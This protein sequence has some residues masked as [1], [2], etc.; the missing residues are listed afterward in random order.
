M[1]GAWQGLDQES[2]DRNYSDADLV[3]RLRSY[4][5]AQKRYFAV[6]GFTVVL[7]SLADL[8]Q[9]VIVAQGVG[10]LAQN[11]SAALM[12]LV[13][14]A[15]FVAAIG[16]WAANLFRRRATGRAIGDIVRQM[17]ED[18]FK[19]AVSRDMSFY[20]EFSS[21]KIVS[22]ITSDTQDFAQM[23]VLVTD[24]ISQ[25]AVLILLLAILF[26]T[27]WRLTLILCLMIP[28]ILGSALMYRNL[29]R[30]VSR[31]ASRMLA[32]V[33]GNIQESV[34]GIAVAKNFRQEAT[35]YDEFDRVN[36]QSYH[37][38][39][40]RGLIIA[41]VYPTLHVLA[42]LGTAAL[43][44][45]GARSVISG[46]IS[47]GAWYLF[48]QSVYKFWD[49]LSSIASFS[50]QVQAGLASAERVFALI[51]APAVVIQSDNQPVP[52]LRGEVEFDQVR[53]QYSDQEIVLPDLSLR[54]APGETVA[55]VGHTGAGKSSIAKLI[56][57]FYEFQGGA[58]RID[59]R[60][61]RTLDLP[62]L[63]RHLGVV[64][65]NPF[66]FSGTVLDNI[67][68]TRPTATEEE[69]DAVARSIGAGEWL[70]TLPNGL[71]SDVGERGSHLSMGQRQLVALTRVLLQAPSI[72]ILDEATASIDPFTESQIQQ[73]LNLILSRSTSILIAHRLST[74]RAADRIIVLQ[75]GAIIETGNHESLLAQGGHYAEL[76]NTY[77][78]HQ[79]L[80]YLNTHPEERYGLAATSG[81]DQRVGQFAHDNDRQ[82]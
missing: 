4:F 38:N 21:G 53:F 27:E 29:A 13:A 5:G 30:R 72:F 54:I 46:V 23:I 35:I 74:V 2:F 44:F 75:K 18:A 32:N 52:S 42:G 25:F 65:Q 34:A 47:A 26:F 31:Q 64:A 40:R 7:I 62:Q 20:D 39:L 1:S 3:R 9:P 43:L 19:S 6:I 78:R 22:R 80:E 71:T 14:G 36:K 76:Y 63:R 55:F 61:I 45:F 67:R 37:V 73:A 33:N 66:L 79:S 28:L 15:V 51:D 24:L 59:G 8:L 50:S 58:I 12:A 68:Y 10:M 77:F 49:P 16:S 81:L 57:R 41:M 48:L 69:V 11:P 82:P 60:D 56:A 70:D 17:R